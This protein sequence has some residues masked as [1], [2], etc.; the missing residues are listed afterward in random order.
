[1]KEAGELFVLPLAPDFGS[2]DKVRFRPAFGK[3]NRI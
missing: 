1:M 2:M 3:Q